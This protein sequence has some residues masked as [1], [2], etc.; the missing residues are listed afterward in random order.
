MKMM[1][2]YQEILILRTLMPLAVLMMQIGWRKRK[3]QKLQTR[4]EIGKCL[5]KPEKNLK[6]ILLMP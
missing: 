1:A 5:R 2:T 6:K 4:N 3:R